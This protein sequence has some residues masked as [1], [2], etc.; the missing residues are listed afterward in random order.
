M[1]RTPQEYINEFMIICLK[2]RIDYF[3]K[4]LELQCESGCWRQSLKEILIIRFEINGIIGDG[5]A[6]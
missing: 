5:V 3:F 2:N 6:F 1:K 4:Y